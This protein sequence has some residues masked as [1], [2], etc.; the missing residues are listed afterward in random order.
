[1]KKSLISIA[2]IV[3]CAAI[4]LCS[5]GKDESITPEKESS[6]VTDKKSEL[7]LN[8]YVEITFEGNDTLGKF[9][10]E[11]DYD[12]MVREN[13]KAFGLTEN[14]ITDAKIASI[15]R[16]VSECITNFDAENYGYK[17][18][19]SHNLSN[20]EETSLIWGNGI[21]EIENLYDLNLIVEDIPLTVSGL[22]ELEKFNPFEYIEPYFENGE[23]YLNEIND[24]PVSVTFGVKDSEGYFSTSGRFVQDFLEEK[25]FEKGDVVTIVLSSMPDAKYTVEQECAKKGY[26]P[27]QTE[28][29]FVCEG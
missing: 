11:V 18:T 8:D 20:G 10:M 23:L 17:M 14:D 16:K 13:P 3:S 9:N 21:Y 4:S 15:W 26:T 22:K 12:S 1:M 7:N 5:C 29:E 19:K 24:M 2:A 28:K 27:T 6:K 25:L